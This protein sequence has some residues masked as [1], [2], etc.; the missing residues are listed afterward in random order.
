MSEKITKSRVLAE[1]RSRYNPL[2]NLTPQSLATA[3]DNF[4]AG[5]LAD[6]AR[7][8]DV[9]ARRDDKIAALRRKRIA[10]LAR[11]GWEIVALDDSPE[12]LAQKATLEHTFN[13][14]VATDALDRDQRGG[15][16]LLLRQ[17]GDAIGKKYAV[18]ELCWNP[19]QTSEGWQM[20]V[21][22]RFAPLWFFENTTGEMRF[23]RDNGG[24]TGEAMDRGAWLIS[25]ADMPLM[26]PSS[27]LYIYKRI[28]LTD[29]LSY[30]ER[31]GTPSVIGRTPAAQGTD[32]GNAMESAVSAVGTDAECVIFGDDGT[33]KIELVSPNGSGDMPFA[34][35]VRRAEEGLAILWQGGD[36]STMSSQA[37]QGTGASLQGDSLQNLEA[38]D[39]QWASETL[40]M[41]IA[42][43]VLKWKFGP[44]VAEK[45]Y[46]RVKTA[47][48]AKDARLDL[49]II[50]KLVELGA[51]VAVADA[52]ETFGKTTPEA[53]EPLLT[54]PA[55][56]SSPLPMLNEAQTLANEARQARRMKAFIAKAAEDAASALTEDLAPVRLA[57]EPLRA[58]LVAGDDA[59]AKAAA[60][61][62]AAFL[63]TK[64]AEI[65]RAPSALQY[66]LTHILSP[67]VIDG[68]ATATAKSKPNK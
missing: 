33:S 16:S 24:S 20:E 45:A 68:I 6:A 47:S 13:S 34:E 46:I 58:A 57:L 43:Q 28:P 27:V 5:Y 65:L 31:F 37:G 53:G 51:P 50:S 14:L 32:A 10:A 21:E 30:S 61:Q 19:V 49:D 8:W 56:P 52:L 54:K 2:A 25:V 67:A 63:P 62:L 66:T 38:D 39:A 3:L 1:R 18:H 42:R 55:A 26:E 60:V 9:L 64:S 44:N 23:I 17:M 11:N 12:A 41:G 7:I 40:Q 29:W 15:L 22:C 36:L 59:A 4:A 35:L 48:A